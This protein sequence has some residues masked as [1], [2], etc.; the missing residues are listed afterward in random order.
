MLLDL[1][2]YSIAKIKYTNN[3]FEDQLKLFNGKLN[4]VVFD[5]GA[6]HGESIKEYIKYFPNCRIFSFEPFEESYNMLKKNTQKYRSVL[7]IK[8]ALGQKNEKTYLFT[9]QSSATNSLLNP[10]ATNSYIDKL[11]KNVGITEV[12]VT[13]IKNMANKFNLSHIDILKLDIQ[14]GELAALKGANKL[15]SE[16]KIKIIY[17]E[18][19]FIEIYAKQPLFND[20][21]TYLMSFNYKLYNIYNLH[22]T[23]SGQLAWGD[24]I[25][26]P[27]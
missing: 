14:G 4:P 27:K 24:A 18:I 10:T 22:H 5:V 1:L 21:T 11:T 23:E 26:L 6:H 19:E 15:L 7:A 12:E 25:Y 16:Q 17:T 2:G 8:K 3:A 9:N 13:T 20:I